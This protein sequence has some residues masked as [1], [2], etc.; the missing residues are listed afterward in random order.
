MLRERAASAKRGAELV[1]QILLFA[2]GMEGPRVA[3][4]PWSL[5]AELKTFLDSSLQSPWGAMAAVQTRQGGR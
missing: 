1:R 2:R 5:F 4:D 3:V